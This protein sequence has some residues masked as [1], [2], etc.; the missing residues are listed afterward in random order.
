MQPGDAGLATLEC[1]RSVR[2][3]LLANLFASGTRASSWHDELPYGL[4][5][6]AGHLGALLSVAFML[7]GRPATAPASETATYLDIPPPPVAE[8]PRAALPPRPP[9]VRQGLQIPAE[10]PQV[11]QPG[12]L[13]G[14]QELLV[15]ARMSGLPAVGAAEAPVNPLDFQ[16][17]GIAGGVA[18]GE[19]PKEIPPPTDSTP[20]PMED[21]AV[22]I[23]YA[24]E[25]PVLLNRAE[26][27]PTLGDLYPPLLRAAGIEGTVKVEFVVATNGRV[28]PGSVRILSST[29]PSLSN[30][31]RAALERFRFSPGRIFHGGEMKLVAVWTQMSI[32]WTLSVGGPR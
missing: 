8:S 28:D 13:A 6:A 3:S 25:P 26:L 24:S 23:K 27:A 21:G 10:L 31:T 20:V 9:V 16:G 18:G 29:N 1:Q 5:S 15:P 4:T 30:A 32:A 12:K 19:K 7:A 22:D 2:V 14:F 11:L 17:R